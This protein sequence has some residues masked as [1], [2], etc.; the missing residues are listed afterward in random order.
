MKTLSLK[1]IKRI[2]N[3]DNAPLAKV[4]LENKSYCLLT[5]RKAQ[6]FALQDIEDAYQEAIFILRTKIIDQKF[7]NKNIA[8]Y[9]LTVTWNLLR[10]QYRRNNRVISLNGSEIELYFLD[11]IEEDTDNWTDEEEKKL[12]VIEEALE[13]LSPKCQAFLR[14]YYKEG[15]SLKR[16][17]EISDYSTYNSIKSTK[18]RCCKNFKKKLKEVL[19]KYYRPI[20]SNG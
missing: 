19:D 9:L 20:H 13:A 12:Q 8:S 17:Y 15:M 18:C 1:D 7:E 2:E 4:Y 11:K 6:R 10:N 5:L 3:G 14:Q 16:M